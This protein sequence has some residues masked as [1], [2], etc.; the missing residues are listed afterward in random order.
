MRQIFLT[1]PGQKINK[2]KLVTF[3][4]IL[5]GENAVNYIKLDFHRKYCR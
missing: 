5:S 3:N 4:E 1:N 2:T